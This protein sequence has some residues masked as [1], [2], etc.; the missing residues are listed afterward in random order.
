VASLG[1]AGLEGPGAPIET[2]SSATLPEGAFLGY[3]KLD[4]AEFEKFTDEVDDEGDY[5][6]F[7]MYGVGYGVRPYLS[8]YA[9]TPFYTK[10][11]EDNSFTTSGFADLSVAAVL[12]FKLDQGLRL[13][14]ANESLDDLE[15]WHFTLNAGMSLPT[16]NANVRDVEGNIDPGMSLGFGSP[17]YSVGLTSTKPFLGFMTS[18]FEASYITFSEYEYDDGSKMKFGDETRLNAALTARLLT[19]AK[20]KLRVDANIE[21]NYLKLGRDEADGEGEEATGGEILYAVPGFRIYYGSTSLGFGIK[22]PV[23]T[24][25]N[26]SEQQQGCEGKEKYRVVVSFSTLF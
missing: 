5:N 18:V 7:W 4:F 14:P 9:F 3:M 25:L 11:L 26:E 6:A 22:K 19:S 13:V 16:G 10:K 2:S 21:A 1:V 8:L 23:W 12:G 24:R 17:S 15:D 20:A